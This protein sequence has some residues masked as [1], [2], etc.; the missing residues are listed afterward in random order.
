MPRENPLISFLVLIPFLII[1][2]ALV[3]AP[4]AVIA[5]DPMGKLSEI[6]QK[7]RTKLLEVKE[8]EKEEKAVRSKIRNIDS[9]I[10]KKEEEL[11]S[12]ENRISATE[13]KI[14]ELTNEIDLLN[15]QF[16]S[17][18]Q[19]LKERILAIYKRQYGGKALVLISAKDYQDLIRKSNYLSLMAYYDSTVINEYSVKAKEADLKKKEL[20]A[21]QERLLADKNRTKSKRNELQADRSEKDRVLA[22]IRVKREMYEK[23]IYEL[24]KSSLKLQTV[25][26]ETRT[27]DIPQAILGAGFTSL[28]GSLPWPVDGRVAVPYGEY[29]DPEFDVASF[30]NGIRVETGPEETV[31]AIAGGRVVYASRLEG[32]GMT[33]IIDHGSGYHS[34]YG[35]LSKIS[36]NS[37]DLLIKGMDVGAAVRPKPADAPLLYFEI[38][39]KG[40][41]VDPMQW[42]K[43]KG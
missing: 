30:E 27:R 37:G 20:E 41:P 18:K 28:K 3:I 43:K 33:L 8:T 16:E 31:K 11:H 25:I 29:R 5:A 10:S 17:R 7:L 34:L 42:L 39:Y 22:S 24:K 26:Q 40:K 36:V 9:T 35:N 38:R 6:Q 23:K 14:N 2:S 32:Y 15:E 1:F 12:Y 13:S 19:Y 4:S 21:L